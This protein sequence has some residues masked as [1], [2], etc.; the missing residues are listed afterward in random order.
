VQSY[1]KPAP[2]PEALTDLLLAAGSDETAASV[3]SNLMNNDDFVWYYPQEYKN[4]IEL[5]FAV[6]TQWRVGMAGATG[7][8][9]VA[10]DVTAKR[11]KLKLNPL[12]WRLLQVMEGE[13]LRCMNAVI[14]KR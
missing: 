12:Q 6:N 8:D 3:L 1:Y 5:F 13:A 4:P 14:A 11:L 10:V 9:Y 2:K 7:L